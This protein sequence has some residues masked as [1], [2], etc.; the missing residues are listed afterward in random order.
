M[1]KIPL[2]LWIIII[3]ILGT[4][5]WSVWYLSDEIV[6]I[7]M[8]WC[9]WICS[10][11]SICFWLFWTIWNPVFSASP[12]LNIFVRPSHIWNR[13]DWIFS[14]QLCVLTWVC[15]CFGICLPIFLYPVNIKSVKL[16]NF[17][18]QNGFLQGDCCQ[19]INT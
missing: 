5:V 15:L 12:C 19:L 16:S 1:L 7:V 11:I 9:C 4:S 14:K 10:R 17:F 2:K 6:I 8:R 3:I 18:P 13:R